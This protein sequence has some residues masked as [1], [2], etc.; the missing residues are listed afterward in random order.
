M[1]VGVAI[2]VLLEISLI[3][4]ARF[5]VAAAPAAAAA[6]VVAVVAV[7]EE[8]E[9]VVIVVMIPWLILE[10]SDVGRLVFR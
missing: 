6:E 8:E 1:V 4:V 10:P 3:L 9:A 5:V 7:V 2:G